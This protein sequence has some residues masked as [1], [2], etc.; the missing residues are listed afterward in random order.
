MNTCPENLQN[1][2]IF[3]S[4][5]VY[6]QPALFDYESAWHGIGGLNTSKKPVRSFCDIS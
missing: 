5:M 3:L 1:K 6:L 4:Q 2:M